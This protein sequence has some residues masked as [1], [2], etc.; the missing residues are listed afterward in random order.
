[1]RLGKGPATALTLGAALVAIA[2]P[3]LL[4]VYFANKTG[5]D[6]EVERA[7][8]YARDALK[9]SEATGD[10]I[11]TAV[12]S[13]MAGLSG[14][15]CSDSNLQLMRRIDLASS[16]IQMIGQVSGNRLVC[17][18]ILDEAVDLGPVDLIQPSGW[19]FRTMR[20]HA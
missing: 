5:R 16:Y 19:K 13:L 6:L 18:S 12:S 10:Q 4:A 17:S 20:C 3:S 9:R 8:V 15:P 14:G 11:W 7:L 1:M 2:V